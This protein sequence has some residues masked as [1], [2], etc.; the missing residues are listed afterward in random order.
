MKRSTDRIL[1]THTGSLPLPVQVRHALGAKRRGEPYDQSVIDTT[2]TSAI[3]EVVRRQIEVGVDIVGDGELSKTAWND[4]VVHRVNGLERKPRSRAR[5][6][7][8]WS[9]AQGI[10]RPRDSGL[11]RSDIEN[12]PRHYRT[13]IAEFHD[14]ARAQKDGQDNGGF[15]YVCTGPI[16]WDDFAAVENDIARL[17]A[18]ITTSQPHDVFMSALSPGCFVRFFRNEYYPNEESYMQAVADVMRQEYQAIADAGFVLQ[19]DCPD[20]A[21]GANTDYAH[22]SVKQFRKVIEK[23]VECLNYTLKTIPREQVRIHVCWGNYEGPHHRDI[24]LSDIID[25]VLKAKVTGIT[26]ESANPRHG[27]EWKIWQETKLPEGKILLPG[28]IDDISHFIE[29][30]ELV[31][32]RIVRF[33]KLVGKENI[34]ACTDC[35]LRHLPDAGLAFAKL[36]ALAE[37]AR[38]ASRELW[39]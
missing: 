15:A 36:Y 11:V 9:I 14:L 3:G 24:A 21:S 32:E 30:P 25:I 13:D 7:E 23:H 27:H 20:L 29:H 17:G 2:L 34:I 19:L 1:T 12:A 37:G 10:V 26:L 22:L 35:G 6:A 31:A 28:V 5:S 38:L 18:A 16:G 33:A 4:Y 39:G 8:P